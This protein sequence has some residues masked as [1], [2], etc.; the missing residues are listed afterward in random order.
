MLNVYADSKGIYINAD[1]F[2]NKS[3]GFK[4]IILLIG[5]AFAQ[6]ISLFDAAHRR[7]TL[8]T[9]LGIATNY[10]LKSAS[11]VTK[12]LATLTF[13]SMIYASPLL[14]NAVTRAYRGP[15]DLYKQVAEKAQCYTCIDQFL[16]D[17]EDSAKGLLHKAKVRG[18][19]TTEEWKEFS[20]RYQA[21][22]KQCTF[23]KNNAT[24]G[25]DEVD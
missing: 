2:N 20:S 4:R 1:R 3:Y 16:R 15:K 8:L 13:L 11:S 6:D 24:F 17:N 19:L 10:A 25:V 22:K 23:H 18:Y 14:M 12:P 7:I 5:A 9:G 21:E